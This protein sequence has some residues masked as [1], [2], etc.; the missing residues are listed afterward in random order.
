MKNIKTIINN[1]IEN[2]ISEEDVR[3]IIELEN[4]LYSNENYF[5]I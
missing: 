2:N 5:I 4:I 3:F 1:Y